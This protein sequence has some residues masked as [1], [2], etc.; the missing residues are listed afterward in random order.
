MAKKG[1]LGRGFSALFNENAT[2]QESTVLLKVADI[3]PNRHQ[4]RKEFD[5]TALAELAESI[6]AHGVLQ[7]ILVRPLPSGTYQIIAGERRWRA[8]RLAQ[9]DEIP[10]VI[11]D[12]DDRE[13]MEVAMIENLQREDL[14]AIEE[15]EGYQL[16]MQAFS[17]TQEQ[18]AERVGKSRSAVANAMRLLNL[19]PETLD[20]VRQGKL[21]AG[22]A[23]ALL[24]FND[25]DMRKQL[26]RLALQGASVRELERA[27]QANESKQKRSCQK[28]ASSSGSEAV[29]FYR[30]VE[31]AL[32][33]ELHRRVVITPTGKGRGTLLLEFFSEEE[34]SDI[35]SRIAGE[36][37]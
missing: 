25:P 4:P 24:R 9:L 20:A 13:V 29:N 12:M 3:E 32:K 1:G 16:L 21:S 23:R 18:I 6:R 14:N 2:D 7:P 5:E 37:W 26:T 33:E 15:A 35:A 27:A 36:N 11:R 8:S 10:A 22:H 31:L 30:E 19:D 28:K 34:L 17:M